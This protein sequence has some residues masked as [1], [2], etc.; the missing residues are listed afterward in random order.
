M[1]V[2]AFETPFGRM[3]LAAEREALV[4]LYLPNASAPVC[5]C[6]TP[7]LAEGK[8]QLLDYFAGRRNAFAL[9]LAPE[10]TA[11]RRQVW[12]A[13]LGIP[14]GETITYGTLAVLVGNPK[15]MRAVGQANHH[16]PIPILIPCHRVIGADGTLTGYG[17]GMALKQELLA[18]E[19]SQQ[20]IFAN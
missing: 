20:N 11:F 2:I 16:N 18:L 10:G 5:G 13:L 12:Q 14:Y 7:L 8:R 3:G 15:G 9:P 6:E 17:G 19:L 4:R 1:D